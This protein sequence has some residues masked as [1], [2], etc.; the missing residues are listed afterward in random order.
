MRCYV[1]IASTQPYLILFHHG[2]LRLCIE[3]F[4]LSDIEDPTQK[5]THIT[6]V[7]V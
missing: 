4:K 7:S 2:Y 6:N 5:F 1:L 3:D